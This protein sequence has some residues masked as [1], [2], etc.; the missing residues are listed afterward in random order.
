M[1][2]N[3][4]SVSKNSY[5]GTVLQIYVDELAKADNLSLH[6][7][8]MQRAHQHGLLS[9]YIFRANEGFGVSR[10]IKTTKIVD[11][12]S[13]LPVL[14]VVIDSVE[15]IEAFKEEISAKVKEGLVFSFPIELD[16]FGKKNS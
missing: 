8:I 12:A 13:N 14:I 2:S 7:W 6:N 15:K 3:Q 10:V 5:S 1:G 4:L 16:V 11:L 9:A